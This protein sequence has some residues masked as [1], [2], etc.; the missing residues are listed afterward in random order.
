MAM[1]ALLAAWLAVPIAAQEAALETIAMTT[2]RMPGPDPIKQT[3]RLTLLPDTRWHAALADES[4][5]LTLESGIFRISVVDGKARIAKAPGVLLSG[6]TLVEIL[7]GDVATMK[8]GDRLIS[9][10]SGSVWV[11]NVGT[12]GAAATVIRVGIPAGT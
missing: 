3:A 9:H 11:E 2:L 12:I 5:I 1:M 6:I 8:A 7:P 4:F 10:D